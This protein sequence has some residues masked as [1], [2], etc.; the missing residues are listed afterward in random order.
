MTTRAQRKQ[1]SGSEARVTV[2]KG[3]TISV[4]RRERET[5]LVQVNSRVPAD[6]AKRLR[7]LAVER[8]L[9]MRDIVE[10]ALRAVLDAA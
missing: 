5:D 10:G 3:A 8:D 6:V 4:R 7:I 2:A 1:A 9:L